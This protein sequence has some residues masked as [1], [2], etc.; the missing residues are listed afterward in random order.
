MPIFSD[1]KSLHI[2]KPER[3]HVELAM[4]FLSQYH[5]LTPALRLEIEDGLFQT[6]YKKGQ[7][8]FGQGETCTALYFI[9]QGVVVGYTLLHN[10]RLTTFICAEGDSVSSISGMYGKKPSGESILVLEDALLLGLRVEKIVALLETS[11]EMNIIIRKIL[12]EFYKSAHDRSNIVRLGT[13]QEKYDY[14]AAVAPQ[15]IKRIPIEY[16]ADYLDINPNTL[17]RL[18][19]KHAEKEDAQLT[20]ERRQLIEDYIMRGEGFRQ[21]GLTITQLSKALSIPVHQLSSLI[22]TT[23]K[24]SFNAFV[25]SYRVIHVRNQLQHYQ[26]WQHL[27]IEALGTQSGFSSR[28]V[29]FAKFK[30]LIGSSP[31][32]YLKSLQQLSP[33]S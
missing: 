6:S 22:N 13:A 29:F 11:I 30:E 2:V 5:P 23:Y 25:N 8:I 17:E 32:E 3:Q 18:L 14:Y 12:E 33:D 27:K 21:Q 4:N 10:K 7:H 15:L 16:I 1:M 19:K 26:Q 20:R 24:K 31:A 9:L 28:S